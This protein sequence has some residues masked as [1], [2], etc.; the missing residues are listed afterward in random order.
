MRVLTPSFSVSSISR[1]TS[2]STDSK[3]ECPFYLFIIFLPRKQ[4]SVHDHGE[5]PSYQPY[6]IALFHFRS[7][8]PKTLFN[9]ITQLLWNTIGRKIL[10]C[11]WIWSFLSLS[12]VNLFVLEY[13]AFNNQKASFRNIKKKQYIAHLLPCSNE[14]RLLLVQMKVIRHF[15][16]ASVFSS[17]RNYTVVCGSPTAPQWQGVDILL[18][19][20]SPHIRLG[21]GLLETYV[22]DC[23]M[24]VSSG[25]CYSDIR[26]SPIAC[27]SN[28]WSPSVRNLT[29]LLIPQI[30]DAPRTL[31]G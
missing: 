14:F 22:S 20:H 28:R 25:K 7:V 2:C 3:L 31:T 19:K 6:A 24:P 4:F 17:D 9:K 5:S 26:K 10:I 21:H 13:F 30:R 27:M 15:H 23:P 12:P 18:P 16:F 29:V 8:S 1:N 11:F